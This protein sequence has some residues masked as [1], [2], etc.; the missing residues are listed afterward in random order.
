M[1]TTHDQQVDAEIRANDIVDILAEVSG[2]GRAPLDERLE[3]LA[4]EFATIGS[5]ECEPGFEPA[6][7]A[8][9]RAFVRD[10]ACS[11]A[12]FATQVREE[13]ERVHGRTIGDR[14]PTPA[15][16]VALARFMQTLAIHGQ[17]TITLGG[18]GLPGDYLHV[19]FHDGYEGGIDPDGRVST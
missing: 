8:E 11:L 16:G 6:N 1:G 3:H 19:R 18:A 7:L 13:Y 17:V 10:H 15:Q 14:I 9:L 4:R 2:P 5:R 12:G